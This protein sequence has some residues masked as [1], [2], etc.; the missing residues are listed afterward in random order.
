MPTLY[1]RTVLPALTTE[2][3]IGPPP[4]RLQGQ[5]T[6]LMLSSA[7]AIGPARGITGD[8]HLKMLRS[9][10]R[11]HHVQNR[12][13]GQSKLPRLKSR[14]S[15]RL[16]GNIFLLT[17]QVRA[18]GGTLLTF[19]GPPDRTLKWGIAFGGGALYPVTD[20]TDSWGR[21]TCLYQAG[22]YVGRVEVRVEYGT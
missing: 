18:T 11:M 20:Y 21:A 5:V 10:G 7:G 3:E 12:L 13:R 9:K 19:I 17:G 16:G 1:G 2:G 14:T 22:G 6:L 15:F 8:V 4:N